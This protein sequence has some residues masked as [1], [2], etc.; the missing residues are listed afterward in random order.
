[1]ILYSIAWYLMV[2]HGIAQNCMVLHGIAQYC[3][4]QSTQENHL[5]TKQI[6]LGLLD[7]VNILIIAITSVQRLIK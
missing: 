5:L 4:V 3:I 6:P 7:V 1:M 2:L